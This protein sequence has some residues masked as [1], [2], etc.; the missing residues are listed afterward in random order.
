[1][2]RKFYSWLKNNERLLNQQGITTDNI[3]VVEESSNSC[4]TVD[5]STY[6][7]LGKIIVWQGGTI[8]TT[9]YDLG[10]DITE[11]GYVDLTDSSDVDFAVVLS[12]YFLKLNGGL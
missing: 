12:D 1:L 2:Q 6:K 9:I 4:V 8:N 11:D 3:I 7:C 10:T 5:Q